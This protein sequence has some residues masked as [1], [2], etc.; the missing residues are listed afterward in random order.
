MVLKT[1]EGLD[2]LCRKTNIP[3]ILP[4]IPPM[5]IKKKQFK[6]R[7]SSFTF[8]SQTLVIAKNKKS[9]YV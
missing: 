9:D 7:N 6:L 5:P 1:N 8:Y 3:K 2:F 4:K